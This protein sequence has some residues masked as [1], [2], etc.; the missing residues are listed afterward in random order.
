MSTRGQ[1]FRR[2]TQPDQGLNIEYGGQ[3]PQQ[4]VIKAKDVA[5]KI[6]SFDHFAYVWGEKAGYYLPPKKYIT[7]RFVA[8]LLANEKQLVKMEQIGNPVELPKVIGVY[9]DELYYKYQQSNDLHSYFPDLGNAH[10]IP[11]NYFFN[12]N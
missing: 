12:V 3:A 11:R 8:Q 6:R 7:W 4:R 5:R 1:N 9:V 10:R 2:A